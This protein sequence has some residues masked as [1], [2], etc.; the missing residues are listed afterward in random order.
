MEVLKK[1][2][3][4]IPGPRDVPLDEIFISRCGFTDHRGE[5]DVD[6]TGRK[7]TSSDPEDAVKQLRQDTERTQNELKFQPLVSFLTHSLSR[8]CFG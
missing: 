4:V 1:I 3:D 5:P 7:L 8:S 2:N 6:S